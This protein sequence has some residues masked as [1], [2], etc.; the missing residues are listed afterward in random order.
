VRLIDVTN[1]AWCFPNLGG[2]SLNPGFDIGNGH[3]QGRSQ[4][5]GKTQNSSQWQSHY[6]IYP[7]LY[8]MEI[9]TDFLCFEQTTFDVAYV[10]ELDPLWQDSALTSILNPEVALLRQSDCRGGLR[11]RL[12]GF[13]GET[14]DR[15]DVL[16]R[17]LQRL[18]VPAERSC[19]GSCDP[20][21]GLAAR[22][23]T[24]ALQGSPPGA[25]MG[26]DGFEGAVPQVPDAGDAQAAIPAA[27]DQSH[28]DSEGPLRLRA[29]RRD[30]DHPAHRQ[31]L[32]GEGR[33]LWL[34]R[35]AQAQL[36]H[37]V[38][39]A[40][41]M[42][43]NLPRPTLAGMAGFLA[44]AAVSAAL[45]QTVGDLDLGAIKT[46]GT[47]Q[48]KDAQAFVDEVAGRGE[49]HRAEAEDLRDEGLKAVSELDPAS[50]P[51]GPAGPVDFDELLSGAAA[52]TRAPMGEGP[53]FTVF[54]SLSM[55]QAS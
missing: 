26:D 40:R 49:A 27:D 20:G 5:G 2:I 24:H 50:L 33:G 18:D 8:W 29:D 44:L 16:V 7:L 46:R 30:H 48:V 13:H 42:I 10:T 38:R 43:R 12:R 22:R 37:A 55:P 9:L 15:P 21:P 45:A 6:Y 1:K 41:A 14:A 23:R 51:K 52:N 11:R 28:F 36:L 54:A 19:P 47:E 17:G 53:L 3:V 35:L 34:P 31:V 4:V 25:G 32:P 39:S